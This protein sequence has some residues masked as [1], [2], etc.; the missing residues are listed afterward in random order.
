MSNNNLGG[1]IDAGLSIIALGVAAKTAKGIMDYT[2]T[3][4]KP[5]RSTKKSSMDFDI[6]KKIWG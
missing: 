6:H 2:K 3:Q 1:I 5:K 4:S